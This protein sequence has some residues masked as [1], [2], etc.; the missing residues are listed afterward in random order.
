MTVEVA[1][2]LE[3]ELVALRKEVAILRAAV[4]PHDEEGE[5]RSLFVREVRRLAR[6]KPSRIYRKGAFSR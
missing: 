5:Y 2:K 6:Q 1:R 4:L 3:R